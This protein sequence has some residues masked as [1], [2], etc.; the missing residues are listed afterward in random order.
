MLRPGLRIRTRV[1]WL[2][3][4]PFFK[5]RLDPDP[6]FI[7][8]SNPD[9]VLKFGRIQSESGLNIKI[10]NPSKIG[11]F[12]QY[13][14]IHKVKI[15]LNL[16]PDSVFLMRTGSFLFLMVGSGSVCSFFFFSKGDLSKTYPDPQPRLQRG[17]FAIKVEMA[18]FYRTCFVACR[19]LRSGSYASTT[20]P[21]SPLSAARYTMSRVR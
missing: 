14:L 12:L 4:D 9:P 20:P 19:A 15:R 11:L 5:M 3:P 16:D 13:L 1:C 7:I 17:A 18:S 2:D 6:V 10:L 8:L 21:A